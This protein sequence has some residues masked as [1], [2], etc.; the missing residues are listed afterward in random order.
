[1]ED[2]TTLVMRAGQGDSAAY[3]QIVYRFQD[4]AVGY[5]FALLGDW[6][7]AEDAAQEA[8][9]SAY[10]ALAKLR[11]AA[12]FPGW[13]RR[14]V[15]T[16][17][18]RCHRGQQPVLVSLDQ[19][20]GVALADTT[21]DIEGREARDEIYAAVHA[22]PEHQRSAILLYYMGSY[23]QQEIA[24][25]LEIPVATVKTRLHHARKQL[26]MRISTLNDLPSQRPSR[27]NQFT[28]KVMRL[29]EATKS[30]DI[31]RVKTLLA[32]DASL[33]RVSGTIQTAL[34]GADAYALHVAVMHGRKDIVD[35]LLAH[36]A[37]I[38]ARDEKYHFTALIHA[39]DLAEFMP[40]YAAL[41]M[42]DFLLERGAEKDVWAC[43]WMGDKDGVKAWLDKDASLVNQTGPGPSTLL[44]FTSDIES[45]DFLLGYG[46]DPLRIY[47]RP[48]YWGR[49]SPLR[50]MAYRGQFKGVRHLLTHAGIEPD[51]Y[52]GSIM[53]EVEAVQSL[54][55]A[56]PQLVRLTTPDD[57]VLGGGLTALHLAAQAG[58]VDLVK[59]LLTHEAYV[60]TR[61][62][63]GMTPLHFVI[64]F[65]PKELFDP[66]PSLDQSAQGLGVYHMLTEI[67]RLLIEHGA[68]LSARES[69]NHLTPLGLATSKLEDET[70]RSELIAL[71]ES[72][73]ATL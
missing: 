12:A 6:Q 51:V 28:E 54:I 22:L 24:T 68:D 67:P 63:K 48:G 45:I 17:V 4:M 53:G 38:N 31:D 49:T 43:W 27:D 64:R 60:N 73:G 21:S 2:L 42:V 16:Q 18:N 34:W 44:S 56:N 46:A 25:F 19:V 13:F 26:R 3:E 39:I 62:Y 9:I 7:G 35:L 40:D 33:A 37:D 71:L 23:S 5:A 52:L 57:H 10:Y 41:N 8:F 61:G 11:D 70:D 47:D 65:G 72:E 36:G 32:E 59:W 69:E 50:E 14:I 20:A 55:T 30:G 66:L 15:W 1:M 29:F 58:H